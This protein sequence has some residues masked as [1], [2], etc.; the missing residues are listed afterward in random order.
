MSN[1]S[2]AILCETFQN[3]EKSIEDFKQLANEAFNNLNFKFEYE[4]FVVENIP[5]TNPNSRKIHRAN[6]QELAEKISSLS[7][8]LYS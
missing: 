4:F 5:R 2:I 3:C 1:N 8:K 7:K 6:A